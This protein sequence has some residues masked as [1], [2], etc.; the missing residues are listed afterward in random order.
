[1]PKLPR[2]SKIGCILLDKVTCF[3]NITVAFDKEFIN[4]RHF[5]SF[6]FTDFQNYCSTLIASTGCMRAATIAG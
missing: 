2:M 4:F 3:V 1:M 5:S 6:K